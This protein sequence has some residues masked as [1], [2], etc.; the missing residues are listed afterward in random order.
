MSV[1]HFSKPPALYK[2]LTKDSDQQAIS[3][4]HPD[5]DS[6][7]EFIDSEIGEPTSSCGDTICNGIACTCIT[8]NGVTTAISTAIGVTDMVDDLSSASRYDWEVIG[9]AI[10]AGISSGL[11]DG[12]LNKQGIDD[13]KKDKARLESYLALSQHAGLFSH[14]PQPQIIE[15]DEDNLANGRDGNKDESGEKELE[16]LSNGNHHHSDEEADSG[17][18][19]ARQRDQEEDYE[20]DSRNGMS[21]SFS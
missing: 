8:C 2:L 17:V 21:P 4:H 9:A 5:Y 19:Y 12:S 13:A 18:I 14:A 20:N 11:V 10:I 7:D 16:T 6:D 1:I 15:F 3:I